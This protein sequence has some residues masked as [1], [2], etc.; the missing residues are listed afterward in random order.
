MRRAITAAYLRR[1]T[2]KAGLETGRLAKT[3]DQRNS[4]AVGLT[5]HG[6]LLTETVRM[7]STCPTHR[8][9]DTTQARQ[10]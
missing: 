6:G 2:L 7:T 8:P 5:S 3:L 10:T 9:N 4:A 1:Q